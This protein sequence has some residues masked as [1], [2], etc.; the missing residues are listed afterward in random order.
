MKSRDYRLLRIDPLQQ[1]DRIDV[2]ID[3]LVK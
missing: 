2:S 3:A 1:M